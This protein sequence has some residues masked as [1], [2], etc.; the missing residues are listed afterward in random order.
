MREVH[1]THRW[2]QRT[3]ECKGCG[4]HMSQDAA[5]QP[6]PTPYKPGPRLAKEYRKP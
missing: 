5:L 3:Q 2:S 6:C 4:T 1:N